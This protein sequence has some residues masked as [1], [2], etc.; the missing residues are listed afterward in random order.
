MILK[1]L[2]DARQVVDHRHAEFAHIGGG[3]DA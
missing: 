2:A 3:P 1:V